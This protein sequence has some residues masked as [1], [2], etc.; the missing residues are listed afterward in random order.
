M[1][2]D[3][4]PPAPTGEAR[5]WPTSASLLREIPEGIPSSSLL[6]F[7][8]NSGLPMVRYFWVTTLE[9]PES[10]LAPLIVGDR[11]VEMRL[12]K[13]RPERFGHIDLRIG[14]FPQ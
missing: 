14:A 6:E 3:K 2:L 10:A 9:S 4:R 1:E 11:L 12:S 7:G 8:S 13:I 5:L